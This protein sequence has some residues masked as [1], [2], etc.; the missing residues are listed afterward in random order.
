MTPGLFGRLREQGVLGDDE[1]D[2]QFLVP[3]GPLPERDRDEISSWAPGL[4]GTMQQGDRRFEGY[5]AIQLF[6]VR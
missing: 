6:R 1:F 2:R 4:K 3:L 5:V